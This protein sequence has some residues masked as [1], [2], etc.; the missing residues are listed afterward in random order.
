MKKAIII[1][2]VATLTLSFTACNNKQSDSEISEK[3]D[4]SSKIPNPYVDC[5]TLE[6]ASALA[7]FEFSVP[8][9]I[10]NYSERIIRAIPDDMIEVIYNN[11]DKEIRIRKASGKED[12]S[13][14]Y[15]DYD[16]E[17]TVKSDNLEIVTR[18]TEGKIYVATW[19]NGDYTYSLTTSDGMDSDSVVKLIQD[20][21]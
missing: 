21:H 6:D 1:I 14:D 16:E 10:E 17:N 18:G 3:S 7:G 19:V 9:A 2:L 15:N 8:D 11:G 5:S 12:I 4:E 20:I 13:G